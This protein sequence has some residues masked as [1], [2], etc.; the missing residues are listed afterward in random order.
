MSNNYKYRDNNDQE[1]NTYSRYELSNID[2][3]LWSAEETIIWLK[4]LKLQ[5]YTDSFTSNSI[6]GYDLCLMTNE[7]LK[8]DLHIIKLHD[9]NLILKSIRE[10][11][12]RQCKY[13]NIM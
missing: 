11:L 7:D 4:T 2:I 6:T 13:K 9:R 12:L 8:N 5:Q 1:Y 10:Y 3:S